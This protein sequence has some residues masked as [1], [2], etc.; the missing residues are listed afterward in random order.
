MDLELVGDLVG[1]Q[2]VRA[3]LAHH[4]RASEVL[5][6]HGLYVGQ[7]MILLSLRAQD[8]MTQ[9]ELAARHGVDLST[10]TRMVQRMERRGYLERRPDPEDARVSRV[11]LTPH[12]QDLCAPAW[13]MWQ[14]LEAQ[15]T[16][17]LDPTERKQLHHLLATVAANLER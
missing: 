11:F 10:I 12:G 7:E 8:G 17:A 2:L 9:S 13:E 5:R 1:G 15:L 4:R 16:A 14:T 3:A 6:G